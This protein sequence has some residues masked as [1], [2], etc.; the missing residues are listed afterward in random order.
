MDR[1]GRLLRQSGRLIDGLPRWFFSPGLQ[2]AIDTVL[3][4][5]AVRLAFELRFDWNIP[6]SH[7]PILWAWTLLLPVLRPVTVRLFGGHHVVWRYFGLH[8]ALTLGIA[9][10]PCTLLMVVMRFGFYKTFWWA[11]IPAGVILI[12]LG[13]FLA[14]AAG[15]RALRRFTYEASG[16][17]G[18][19]VR[20]LVLGTEHSL[21]SAVR[22]VGRFSGIHIVGLLAMEEHLLG[23]L[24][25]GFAVIGSPSDL[26]RLLAAHAIDLILLSDA[27]LD[28]VGSAVATATEF[29]VE[30]R[31]LPSAANVL[32]GEVRISTLPNPERVLAKSVPASE[33][34]VAVVTAFQDRV[35]LVTGAGGSIGS[36]VCRQVRRL[37]VAKLIMLD[38]DENAIFEICS[39]T[40]GA[41]DAGRIVPLIG[42]IQDR[43]YL[44]Q[45]FEQHRPHIVLHAAAYKH[46]TVMEQNCSQAILNNVT[47]TRELLDA[48]IAFAAERFLM[49]STDKAVR[50]CSVMG[51][52]KRVAEMLVQQR[53]TDNGVHGRTRCACVRFG[54]VLGS[55]GS[56][57]PIFLAQI[58]AG[59]PVTITD[60]DMT[61]YFMTIPE[62]VQLVLQAA[63]LGSEG[64]VY[65]LDMGDPVRIVDLARK[66][67]ELSGLRPGKDIEI[68]F[69]GRRPG[70]KISEQLWLDDARVAPTDFSRVFAVQPGPLPEDFVPLLHCLEEA[71]RS[72]NNGRL[73]AYLEQMPI[74]FARDAPEAAKAAAV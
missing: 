5:L 3:A 59:G 34:H 27:N 68:R 36:E 13:A 73:V 42:D 33:P 20:A 38:R 47:G 44:R 24:I 69:V 17:A 8:D 11:Q 19:R 61:R 67:I 23:L 43:C 52:S 4:L 74:E 14:L 63:T 2:L 45:L 46:V 26:P 1:P 15:I 25:G 21:A 48:A 29:G 66:L 49:I 58:A 60:E 39:Q 54:N 72:G 62:A 64:Q 30:I 9:A 40:N 22:Q 41:A 32:L 18:R 55:R 51:A 53:A 6:L 50:P 12:E 31:L 35:V 57:V 28:C 37:P 16:G 7:Q 70:E 71:A 10:L 65:M 56:V